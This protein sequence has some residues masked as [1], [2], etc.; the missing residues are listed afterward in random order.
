MHID[1]NKRPALIEEGSTL[2]RRIRMLLD[3]RT[4]FAARVV[5]ATI[6]VIILLSC[7]SVVIE[8]LPSLPDAARPW[9]RRFEIFSV[10]VFTIEYLLRVFTARSPWRKAREPMVLIDLLA[11]LPF[12]VGIFARTMIDLRFLRILRSL[13]VLRLLKMKRYINALEML[14]EVVQASKHQL[15]SFLFVALVVLVLMGSG[16]YNVEPNTFE[17]IPNAIWWS[18][19]TL[20]TVGYGDVVPQ[21]GLGQLLASCVMMLGIGVVAV[22]TGII[23]SGM[24]DYYHK[25]HGSACTSC[26]LPAHDRD[27][28]FCKR[29]GAELDSRRRSDPEED[30]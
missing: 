30:E 3:G 1:P 22:P 15:L 13:R 8:T 27:A 2:K 16:L 24:V 23:S 9:L 18:V 12:Y 11:I 6:I 26:E 28:H 29:C 19:V 10:G 17:S 4:T 25:D 7:T 5:D 21:T 20:T 14:M